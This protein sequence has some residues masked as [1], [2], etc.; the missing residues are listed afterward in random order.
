MRRGRRRSRSDPRL[1]AP[2]GR[3]PGPAPRRRCGSPRARR[4]ARRWTDTRGD[5][6]HRGLRAPRGHG[7]H[8]L[9]LARPPAEVYLAAALD[10]FGAGHPAVALDAG[11]VLQRPHGDPQQE[12]EPH[13]DDPERR[14]GETATNTGRLAAKATVVCHRRSRKSLAPISTPSSTKVTRGRQL[15]HRQHHEGDGGGVGRRRGRR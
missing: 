9:V 11:V 15:H 5:R 7:G 13:G 10:R 2:R 6:G 14:P 12:A 1:G 3:P 4:P 8:V